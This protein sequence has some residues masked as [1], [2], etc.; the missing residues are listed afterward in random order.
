MATIFILL[1]VRNKKREK[2]FTHIAWPNNN[3]YSCKNHENRSKRLA[4]IGRETDIQRKCRT[5]DR[6]LRLESL[7]QFRL[8]KLFLDQLPFNSIRLGI[9][10][11]MGDKSIFCVTQTHTG[12]KGK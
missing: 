11:K 4:A 5:L 1:G 9:I 10:I 7:S 8:N 12:N 3:K 6:K 2:S